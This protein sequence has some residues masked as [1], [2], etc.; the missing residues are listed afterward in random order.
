M[1][2]K[3]EIKQIIKESVSE[4]WDQKDRN[5]RNIFVEIGG[6]IL[7]PI[8]IASVSLIVTYKINEAQKINAEKIAAA[9]IQ[10]SE[11]I[12]AAQR[13][14]TA[15]IAFAEREVQRLQQ[16]KNIFDEIIE[17][18]PGSQKLEKTK[19]QIESLT[20]HRETSLP[21]L[22]RIRDYFA[23]QDSEDMQ[24][25]AGHTRKTIAAVLSNNHL[26][27]KGMDFSGKE[28][29]PRI[30]RY[31]K[32]QEY[33]LSGAQFNNCNLFRATFKQSSLSGAS[34]KNSDLFGAD[35]SEAK[36][37]GA[38]FD[39]ANLR[40][41]VFT[42]SK[43]DNA[44]FEKAINLED[45]SFSLFSILKDHDGNNPFKY[46]KDD[47]VLTLLVEHIDELKKIRPEN[48][49][50]K[51]FLKRFETIVTYQELIS[52][53]EKRENIRKNSNPESQPPDRVSQAALWNW[54][55]SGGG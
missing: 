4:I 23:V 49:N 10:S 17:I 55:V 2:N 43:I 32:L 52:N 38:V 16:I 6:I 37:D 28:D 21:F 11:N 19:M 47:T 1:S 42:G 41:A 14:H 13:K 7:T 44:K 15:Q 46:V 3:N 34:F 53:L 54:R 29:D 50:L 26:S 25:L 31:A 45:A 8:V 20:V 12:A 39:H 33:N 40:Q 18:R 5:K 48:K 51:E 36:L 9:Q 35:F 30:L 22:V 27:F 24:Q